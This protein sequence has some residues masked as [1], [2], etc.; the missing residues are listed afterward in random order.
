M[1]ESGRACALTEN[2]TATAAQAKIE[3]FLAIRLIFHPRNAIIRKRDFEQ[4]CKYSWLT[5]DLQLT[6]HPLVFGG[7]LN[8]QRQARLLS[9]INTTKHVSDLQKLAWFGGLAGPTMSCMCHLRCPSIRQRSGSLFDGL[10]QG[11]KSCGPP[12]AIEAN[13]C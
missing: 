7:E 6:F 1:G 8:R 5:T 13:R 11:S 10:G 4:R 9:S 2:I 3:A 12:R